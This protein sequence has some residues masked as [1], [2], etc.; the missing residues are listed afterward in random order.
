MTATLTIDDVTFERASKLT[1]IKETTLLLHEAL[2]ALIAAESA[3]SLAKFGGIAPE[4]N[5]IP[6]R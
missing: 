6:R 4:L 3:R 1:G 5:D 2:K